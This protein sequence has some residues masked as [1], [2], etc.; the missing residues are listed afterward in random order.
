[1]FAAGV[2][3][4]QS[5]L[6]RVGI[7]DGARIGRNS[8]GCAGHQSGHAGALS[9][10]KQLLEPLP[11]LTMLRK[12]RAKRLDINVHISEEHRTRPRYRAVPPCYSNR[13]RAVIR[14]APWKPAG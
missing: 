1:M 12:L 8:Q 5:A 2:G 14:R 6:D 13:L 9:A 11:H 10:A 3:K 7:L 4:G